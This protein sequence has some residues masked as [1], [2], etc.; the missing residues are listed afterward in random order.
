MNLA[1]VGCGAIAERWMRGLSADVRVAVTAC[2]DTDPIAARRFAERYSIPVVAA[3]MHELREV[4][5]IVNLTPP[6]AHSPIIIAALKHG[7]HVLT[8]KPLTVTTADADLIDQTARSTGRLVAVMHNRVLDPQFQPLA[9]AAA[10]QQ[11]LVICADVLVELPTAGFRAEMA[12]P[13]LTDLAVHAFDQVQALVDADPVQIQAHEVPLPALG[14][15]CSLATVTVTFTDG[16]ALAYRGGFVSAG[17]RTGGTGRWQ[18]AGPDGPVVPAGPDANGLPGYRRCLTA[19]LDVLHSP[20]RP[21]GVWPRQSLRSVALLDAAARSARTGV[22]V[23]V[24]PGPAAD[25]A[26]GGQ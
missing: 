11:P 20:D 1:V 18:L 22:P 16:S 3:G 25:P 24:T 15:H 13:V 5:A 19:M 23:T 12:Q 8:E 7:W 26:S 9:A 2:T 6:T 21:C 10:G 17:L 4:D 14:A